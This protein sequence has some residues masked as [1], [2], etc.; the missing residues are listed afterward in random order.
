MARRKQRARFDIDGSEGK[1]TSKES[2]QFKEIQ[3]KESVH[4]R[5]IQIMEEKFGK[6]QDK[7]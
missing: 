2:S 7:K 4:F 6:L 1:D 5:W 3:G